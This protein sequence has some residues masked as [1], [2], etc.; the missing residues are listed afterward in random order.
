MAKEG[1]M[2]KY[3]LVII[4]TS[5][6]ITITEYPEERRKTSSKSDQASYA[7]KIYMILSIYTQREREREDTK[8]NTIVS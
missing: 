4:D 5:A 2:F 7:H 3:L 6:V 8:H 1:G